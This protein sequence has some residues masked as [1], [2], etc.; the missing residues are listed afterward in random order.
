M[1][2]PLQG[3]LQMRVTNIKVVFGVVVVGAG[4]VGA[5]VVADE[6]LVLVLQGELLGAEEEHVLA[7]VGQAGQVGRVGETSHLN[8]QRGRR[9]IGPLV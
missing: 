5:P 7:E 1:T 6:L 2:E 9:K 3:S 8:I 4:V